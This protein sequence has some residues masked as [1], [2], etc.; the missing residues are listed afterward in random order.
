MSAPYF[1][2]R[3]HILHFLFT[4][5]VADREEP[6]L[7]RRHGLAGDARSALRAARNRFASR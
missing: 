1:E 3:G 4:H 2:F 5:L 7:D 6:F